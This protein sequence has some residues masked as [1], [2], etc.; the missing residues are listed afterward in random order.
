MFKHQFYA[1][2][3]YHKI[4]LN[5]KWN[6]SALSERNIAVNELEAL[7]ALKRVSGKLIGS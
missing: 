4:H 5:G 3:Q 6:W 2:F 1:L 7:R